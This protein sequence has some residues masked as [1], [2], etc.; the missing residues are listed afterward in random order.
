GN[1]VYILISRAVVDTSDGLFI[2]IVLSVVR[3]LKRI[4]TRN[5]SLSGGGIPYFKHRSSRSDAC[6]VRRPARYKE[7]TGW[8][9][10]VGK[11][12]IVG[13][14]IP[15]TYGITGHSEMLAIW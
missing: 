4:R 8:L 2:S 6:A 1:R 9:W 5:L 15:N 12:L 14:S 10:C 13:S 11:Y 7:A 3:Q